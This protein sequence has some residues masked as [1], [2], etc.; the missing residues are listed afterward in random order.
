MEDLRD[1]NWWYH[2]QLSDETENKISF[3]LTKDIIMELGP[4]A[5][6]AAETDIAGTNYIKILESIG[7]EERIKC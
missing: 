1:S 4:C 3:F 7:F 6:V 2:H 5:A